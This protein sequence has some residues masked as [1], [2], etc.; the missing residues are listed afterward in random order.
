MFS[1]F[2]LVTSFRVHHAYRGVWWISFC[3]AGFLLCMADKLRRTAGQTTMLLM[4]IYSLLF[5]AGIERGYPGQA[6]QAEFPYGVGR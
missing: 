6:G 2:H 5:L 4:L 3:S 1:V